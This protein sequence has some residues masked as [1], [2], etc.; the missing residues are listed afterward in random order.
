MKAFKMFAVAA[1]A[2]VFC[3]GAGSAQAGLFDWVPGFQPAPTYQNSYLP[4]NGVTCGPNGCYRTA[5]SAYGYGT[6]ANGQ[7]AT[8]QCLNG[9]CA[10]GSCVNGYCPTGQYAPGNCANGQCYPS[11]GATVPTTNYYRGSSYNSSCPGGVCPTPNSYR[12]VNYQVPTYPS[13]GAN[14][15]VP[16]NS[17]RN[18]QKVPANQVTQARFSA[19][20]P[21]REPSP[22]YP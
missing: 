12:P 10:S 3:M 14:Y 18:V 13:R 9:Q 15:A 22:F 20:L 11:Y 2:G 7:C 21:Q 19:P 4:G 5:P 16:G 8:G 1:V 17:T 6:C